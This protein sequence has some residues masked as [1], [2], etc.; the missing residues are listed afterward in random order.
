MATGWAP[1]AGL[2][3]QAGAKLD[4]DRVLE[5]IRPFQMPAGVFAAG[6]VNGIHL[7]EDRLLDGQ[8]AAALPPSSSSPWRAIDPSSMRIRMTL[9][10]L[11]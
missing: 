1:A 11:R 10:E 7:L 2:L 6:K 5:Q 4:Y 9:A 8:A 3:Y